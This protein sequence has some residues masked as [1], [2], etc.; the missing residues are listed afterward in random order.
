VIEGIW[1]TSYAV[2]AIARNHSDP[3]ARGLRGGGRRRKESKSGGTTVRTLSSGLLYGTL[4]NVMRVPGLGDRSYKTHTSIAVPLPDSS[5][6]YAMAA[7]RVFGTCGK[8]RMVSR[9]PPAG[10]FSCGRSW[11]HPAQW[12]KLA[13]SASQEE[14]RGHR[15][16][17]IRLQV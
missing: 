5:G 4:R 11:R 13:D 16:R 9:Y 12:F 2:A 15:D 3:D 10:R 1:R 17:T 6:N 8:V 7:W 14:T